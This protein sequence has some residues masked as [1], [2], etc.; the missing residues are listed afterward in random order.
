MRPGW[1]LVSSVL[2]REHVMASTFMNLSAAHR[3]HI[4]REVEQWLS[5]M[6]LEEK[7]GQM[8]QFSSDRDTTGPSLKEDIEEEIKA[9]RVGS[10]FNAFDA[11]FTR[12][13]QQQAVE[14][15]R[16]GIPLLFG[17]D[18]IHGFRTIFPIPLAQ[19]ASFDMDAIEAASRIAAAEASAAGL[20][21]A[22]TPMVDITR[23]PRWGRVMEGAGEDT[24]LGCRVA[25]AQVRGLQGSAPDEVDTVAA[26]VKHF[27]GYGA[28]E[29]GRDYNTVD[30]S[31][32]RL[33][34]VYL[35]PFQA[36]IDEGCASLM[37]AF[38]SLNG[39]PASCN[40]WLLEQV[41]RQ[42]WGFEGLVVTDYT[43]IMELVH[44]GVAADTRQAGQKAVL[45]GVDMA[46][47]DGIFL[48]HLA[49]LVEAGTVSI[50]RIDT[51]VRRILRV[52]AAL[53]LLDDPYRYSDPARE[54]ALLL[55]PAHRLAARE[56]AE[57]ACVL[58]RN[59]PCV[60]PFS[61]DIR[62]MAVIGPLAQDAA[63]M[64]GPWH[65][66]GQAEDAVSLHDGLAQRLGE[67]VTLDYCCGVPLE[68][69]GSSADDIEAAA[70]LARTSDVVV[71]ALG[72][73]NSMSGEAASRARIGLP[74][75][76]MALARAVIAT[77]TPCAVIT[78][79]GRP[80][81]LSD[82]DELPCAILHAWWPGI[83]AGHALAR[84]LMGDT[85]PSG[86]LPMTF[87]RDE[88]QIP[89]HYNAFSTGRPL[90]PE[91]KYTSKYLDMPNTPLYPFGHG[92]T[93]GQ[94]IYQHRALSSRCIRASE[95]LVVSVTVANTGAHE[96]TEV[97]QLYLRGPAGD[98]V[99]PVRELI[100]FKRITLVPGGA[101]TVC[102]V[103]E[104]ASLRYEDA[105]GNQ[106]LDDGEYHLYVGG[107][108]DTSDAVTFHFNKQD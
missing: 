86:R 35:P 105:M 58:L 85:G 80:L 18:V 22:F 27:A 31:E 1:P 60:L 68:S 64:L 61:N 56:L 76:Q 78:F 19:A 33:R 42:E 98:M 97:V 99:R 107:R 54:Q 94:I 6:T 14:H 39:V 40:G 88:G 29:A 90:D 44:H 75:R 21:W 93:Y 17:Y 53:G 69:D 23:D 30:V 3:E 47:Q 77:G 103:I 84:L 87:P 66:N 96:A 12:R 81:V 82:L 49:G 2:A 101:E 89:I 43:A 37:T 108:S 32:W 4:D 50:E 72:E 67:E 41:L 7:V 59:E 10:V 20:H 36:A 91:E 26:C 62:R 57:K 13:L 48:E 46:M 25:R 16:L 71:L 15:T 9:G 28:A 65:G 104:A 95:S 51:A 74:G 70:A 73:D 8:T 92:L 38:N 34:S 83:E 24:L 5:C 106:R 102:F 45:A 79:S 11:D 55:A 63:A 52:K 100:D